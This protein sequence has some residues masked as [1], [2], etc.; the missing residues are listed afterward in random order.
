MKL[1][2][3]NISIARPQPAGQK[4]IDPQLQT[5]LTGDSTEN[6]SPILSNAYQQVVWVYRAVN[7]IAE[8]IA[9]I[10]FLFSAGDRGERSWKAGNGGERSWK[11]GN[12][13]ELGLVQRS[14]IAGRRRNG[15]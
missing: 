12:G 5:W 2:G 6:S 4:S 9:N 8:Q 13:G 15:S 11:A 1:F 3:F 10:P 7:V 14:W